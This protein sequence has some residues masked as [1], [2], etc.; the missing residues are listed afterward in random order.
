MSQ[1]CENVAHHS[2]EVARVVGVDH[3]IQTENPAVRIHVRERHARLNPVVTVEDLEGDMIYEI[4]IS[5]KSV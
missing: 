2:E 3:S 1:L 4:L 5:K